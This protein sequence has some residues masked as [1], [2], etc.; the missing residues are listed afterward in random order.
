MT[1]A[2]SGR[3]PTVRDVAKEAGVS[4]ATVSRVLAGAPK[5][6]VGGTR[7]KV[8]DAA[9]RLGY[10]TNM[11]AKSLATGKSGTVGVMVP[12]LGNQYFTTIVQA[13]VHAARDD[14]FHVLVGDTLDVADAEPQVARHTLMRSDGLIVC[15]PRSAELDLAEMLDMGKPTVLV[16]RRLEGVEGASSVVTDTLDTTGRLVDHLLDHGHR[17]IAFVGANA[18]SKQNNARWGLIER[19]TAESGA[20]SWRVP[21]E[22]AEADHTTVLGPL[23]EQGCTAIMAANDL[24][25]AVVY[26]AVAQL[27]RRVPD[28]VSVVGF[29]DTPIARWLRPRLTTA[30][31][32]ERAVGEAAWSAMRTLLVDPTQVTHSTFSA[33]AV[34]RESVT[35]A[36]QR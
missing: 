8:M 9:R 33:D 13:V 27:N 17:A 5:V 15:S 36:P 34:L 16:N 32:H 14:G 6:V 24:Q 7:I 26:N 4:V 21:L 22:H 31:M 20:L 23:L 29:D 2:P 28:D 11:A 12:D 35:R 1:S 25:A 3:R 19:R 18:D 10:V 30:T